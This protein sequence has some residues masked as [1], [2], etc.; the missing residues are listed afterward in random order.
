VEATEDEK[1]NNHFREMIQKQFPKRFETGVFSVC[2]GCSQIISGNQRQFRCSDCEEFQQCHSCYQAKIHHEQ[3]DQ[4]C[5]NQFIF[6]LD[7][8][9]AELKRK[10]GSSYSSSVILDSCLTHFSSR[11]FIGEKVDSNS[12]DS[13]YH[14]GTV[15]NGFRWYTF[16]DVR[17]L[18]VA[19]SYS[20]S[21]VAQFQKTDI[22]GICSEN[23]L[24]WVITDFACI[25]QVS[26]TSQT[27]FLYH[28]FQ[29]HNN[30]NNQIMI[31]IIS[32]FFIVV[33]I[34]DT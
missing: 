10:I 22:I 1:E 2:S 4:A 21:Q 27:P 12:E 8:P 16:E 34:R 32:L 7:L 18:L 26:F 15:I 11:K 13:P 30:K 33:E 25:H 17:Q 5:S 24:E 31:I 28:S 23:R 20:F 3:H 6:Q 19:L 14:R 29:I 9:P